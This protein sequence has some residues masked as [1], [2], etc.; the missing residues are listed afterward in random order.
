MHKL[1]PLLAAFILSAPL[2]AQPV[3]DDERGY[4]ERGVDRD[5]RTPD[6]NYRSAERPAKGA[7]Y[8]GG[9]YGPPAR[10]ADRA[11]LDPWLSGTDY[12]AL[13][14]KQ[15]NRSF[16]KRADRDGNARLTDEEISLAL[17]AR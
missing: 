4:D 15:A 7:Y 10:L 16:R 9:R 6:W 5:D 8:D 17:A 13:A 12:A 11:V 3:G 14:P 1:V 2:H